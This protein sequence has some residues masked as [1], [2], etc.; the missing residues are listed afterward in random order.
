VTAAII[1]E[2]AAVLCLIAALIIR[3]RD[4]DRTLARQLEQHATERAEADK[5]SQDERRELANR[6]QHPSLLPVTRKTG[7]TPTSTTRD[8]AAY[9]AV[10]RARPVTDDADPTAGE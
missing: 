3:E 9:A 2:A 5:R 10:G 8:G 6:I 4:H 7:D 1:A